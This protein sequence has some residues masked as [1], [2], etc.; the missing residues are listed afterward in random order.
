MVTTEAMRV[1][2]LDCLRWAERTPNPVTGRS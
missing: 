2:A 1:F